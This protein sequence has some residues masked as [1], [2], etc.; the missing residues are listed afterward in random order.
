VAAL[1][2]KLEKGTILITDVASSYNAVARKE[3]DITHKKVNSNKN[4]SEKPV[5][6]IHL[7]TVNNQHKQNPLLSSTVQW[8][9]YQIPA[10]TPQLVCLQAVTTR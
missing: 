6:K 3:K 2:G 5:G 9:G 8:G 1:E 7:Q 10:Q 4:R